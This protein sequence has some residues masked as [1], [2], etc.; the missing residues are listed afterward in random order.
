MKP[1]L[2]CIGLLVMGIGVWRLIP[3]LDA[4]NRIDDV[5]SA[6]ENADGIRAE[7]QSQDIRNA[8]LS[9][10]RDQLDDV[11]A[12]RLE[13]APFDPVL[14]SLE[15]VAQMSSG[16]GGMQISAELL[17]RAQAIA[18]YDRRVQA[19]RRVVQVR[20]QGQQSEELQPAEQGRAA[21]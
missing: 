21:K 15:A 9:G 18:P 17:D 6:F 11:I 19:I 7:V 8:I 5:S 1:V 13:D 20:L 4:I 3:E 12:T 14:M 2:L 16:A 10:R